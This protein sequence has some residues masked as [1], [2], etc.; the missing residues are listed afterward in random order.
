MMLQ[1][2]DNMGLADQSMGR[3]EAEWTFLTEQL[4]WKD[5]LPKLDEAEHKKNNVRLEA[6][7]L[8]AEHL[9]LTKQM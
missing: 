4:G 8:L 9:F 5:G 7:T 6:I 2:N 1:F 3:I